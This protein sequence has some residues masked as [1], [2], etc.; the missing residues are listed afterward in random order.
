MPYKQVLIETAFST[1]LKQTHDPQQ[2]LSLIG[3]YLSQLIPAHRQSE[4][5]RQ[6]GVPAGYRRSA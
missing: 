1:A 6:V 5:I 2:Q 4:L 3:K